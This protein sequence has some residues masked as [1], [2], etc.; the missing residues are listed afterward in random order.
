[1][2]ISAE[3]ENPEEIFEFFDWLSTVE[4]QTIAQYGV[5]GVSMI[6]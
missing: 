6:W 1:M 2:A 4:G 3:A 5:E